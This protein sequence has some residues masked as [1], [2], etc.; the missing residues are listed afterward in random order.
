MIVATGGVSY[1]ATGSTGDGYRFARDRGH[2][3]IEPVPALAPF[4]VKE[5]EIKELMGLSLKHVEAVVF[6]QGRELYREFGE[7]LFTHFGVSGPIILSAS[8]FVARTLAK[9]PLTLSIDLKP[10]LDREQLDA[11]ILKDFEE[12]SNK[13][14]KNSLGRLFPAKLIPV[15]IRRSGISPEKKVNEITRVQRLGLVD[16]TKGLTYT[17]TG[18]G[19]FKE[20]IITQGALT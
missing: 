19:D 4:V 8:S 13:Q 9:R 11:R 15:M 7:L 18:L 17:L 10:A 20:A 5:P 12:C 1:E 14:F 16:A 3:I 2:R 6:D